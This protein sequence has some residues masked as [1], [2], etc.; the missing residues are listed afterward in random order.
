MYRLVELELTQHRLLCALNLSCG[1]YFACTIWAPLVAQ[2]FSALA[3]IHFVMEGNGFESWIVLKTNCQCKQ[4]FLAI[5]QWMGLPFS[6]WLAVLSNFSVVWFFLARKMTVSS[7]R[8]NHTLISIFTL[9][10]AI[11]QIRG[12][13][14]TKEVVMIADSCY[15]ID[16]LT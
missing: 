3:F 15:G 2:C 14:N 10:D 11:S 13:A 6:L 1:Y 9:A 5:G 4:C 12:N 16:L 8:R 7:V